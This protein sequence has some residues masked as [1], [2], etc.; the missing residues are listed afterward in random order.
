MDAVGDVCDNC[1]LVFNMNQ[2]DIDRDG[3]GDVCDNCKFSANSNQENQD[4]D[5]FGDLCDNDDDNDSIC[6]S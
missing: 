1:P 4:N 3:I 2:S 6:K 5:E